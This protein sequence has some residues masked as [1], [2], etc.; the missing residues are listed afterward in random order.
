MRC[1]HLLKAPIQLGRRATRRRSL[2]RRGRRRLT[3]RHHQQQHLQP[4]SAPLHLNTCPPPMSSRPP[5]HPLSTKPTLPCTLPLP[6]NS[7][8][9]RLLQ[10][11]W[12]LL[13]SSYTLLLLSTMLRLLLLLS[14]TLR[15]PPLNIMLR[16][17]PLSTMLLR[18]PLS[19]MLRR[20]PLSIMLP[21]LLLRC[22]VLRM[23]YSSSSGSSNLILQLLSTAPRSDVNPKSLHH[24]NAALTSTCANY[25]TV[26]L[27][28]LNK[29]KY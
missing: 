6:L 14:T 13:L 4:F 23:D 29:E 12:L 19:T 9:P 22:M 1:L 27:R 28:R 3:T 16:R 8:P 26:K 21:P 20:M 7:N 25:S 5:L 2:N 15:R 18:I 17:L 11:R 10:H 24:P